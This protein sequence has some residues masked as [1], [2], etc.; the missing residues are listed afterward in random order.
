MLATSRR[1]VTVDFTEPTDEA[2]TLDQLVDRVST[3]VAAEL[4]GTP[5]VVCGYSLGAVVAARF[6]ARQPQAVRELV[7]ICGWART[8]VQQR[9]RNDVWA[10][11]HRAGDPAAL[12][13]YSVFCAFSGTYLAARPPAEIDTLLTALS[14]PAG[15]PAQMA[16]NRDID[17]ADDLEAITAPTLVIGA[18]HDHM[19]PVPHSKQLWGAI[20]DARYAEVSAGHAVLTERPA[21][22]LQLITAFLR[23]P[24][25]VPSGGR[26]D[27][28]RP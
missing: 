27:A 25:A 21:E 16:L 17:I 22:V 14:V 20:R 9:L 19:A 8:D 24:G 23:E 1:V 4:A 11:L 7:L 12:A 2:L 28:L 6:A 10:T 5:A 18:T 3:V 15:M 13:A 26:V